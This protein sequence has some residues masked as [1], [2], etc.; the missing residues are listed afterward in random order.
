M[1]DSIKFLVFH[2]H[3]EMLHEVCLETI[4]KLIEEKKHEIT[5]NKI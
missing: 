3:T 4:E 1:G 2:T 5:L